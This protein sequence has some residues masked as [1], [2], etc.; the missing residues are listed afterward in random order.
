VQTTEGG[1]VRT[2]VYDVFGQNI[3]DY[4]GSSGSTLERENIY[5]GGQ[6]LATAETPVA[7]A[8]SGLRPG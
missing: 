8:P 5:R 2:M 3:A 4:V 7:A 6:L 1:T